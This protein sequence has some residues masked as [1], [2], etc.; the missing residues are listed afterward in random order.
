MKD[1]AGQAQEVPGAIVLARELVKR[2]DEAGAQ[3]MAEAIADPKVR[4]RVLD[5]MPQILVQASAEAGDVKRAEKH[6]M[7]MPEEKRS[8]TFYVDIATA[9]RKAGDRDGFHR[10]LQGARAQAD[11]KKNAS[12]RATAHRQLAYHAALAGDVQGALAFARRLEDPKERDGAINGAVNG[13]VQSRNVPAAWS[14]LPEIGPGQERT[15]A[16]VTTAR[17]AVACNQVADLV[18]RIDALPPQDRA[19]ACLGVIESYV[20]PMVLN[21]DPR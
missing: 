14:L 10:M 8:F 21:P 19:R 9:M 15:S 6:L 17:Y 1:M 20:E 3:K 16:V 11:L 13:C 5:T 18:Q 2:G 4:Q 7:A 12:F